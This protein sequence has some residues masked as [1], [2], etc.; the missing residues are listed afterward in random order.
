LAEPIRARLVR[1][2]RVYLGVTT[3]GW[4]IFVACL[5]IPRPPAP[6]MIG[7]FI[8]TCGGLLALLVLVRCP[9]CRTRLPQIGFASAL[10]PASAARHSH[11]P[12][13]GTALDRA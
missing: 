4:L 13:C 9:R 11:C 10:A 7:A 12:G 1:T 2:T 8:A 3:A 6:L 5:F